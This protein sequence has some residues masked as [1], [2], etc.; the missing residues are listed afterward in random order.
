MSRLAFLSLLLLTTISLAAQPRRGEWVSYPAAK[1]C[2]GGTKCSEKRL[3]VALE[4]RPVVGVRFH[5]HDQIG[6]T[7]GGE[8]RIKVGADTVEDD[9]DISRNGQTYTIDVDNLRGTTLTFEPAAFDEVEI[10]DV[11]VL[12]G[13]ERRDTIRRDGPRFG[14]GGSGSMGWRRYSEGGCIGRA[15]CRQK[16][17]RITIALEDAPVI[18]IR[19]NAHDNVGTKAD[20]KLTVRIDDTAIA[21]YEDVRREGKRHEYEVDNVRGTRLVISTATDDD[22]TVSDV[23]VLYGR[24]ERRY[25]RGGRDRDRDYERPRDTTHEGGCIGG[26]ECGGRRARL[27]IPL[28]DYA[29]E[30]IRFYAHDNVGAKAGGKLSV[31]IDD[32]SVRSWIDVPRDGKTFTLDAEGRSGRWLVI[33]VNEDDEVVIK[34]VRVTYRDRE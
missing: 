21:S 17:D 34:D 1:G 4:D 8:L 9:L 30:E 28:R 13:S 25:E 6:D 29:V 7:A 20:G 31:S 32:N 18:G 26:T 12:Y 5:A 11:E 33:E 24:N 22:V 23:E 3:R 19:F 2:I 10:S 27:R 15:D 14:G 16:G